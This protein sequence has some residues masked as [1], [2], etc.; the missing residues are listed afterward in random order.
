[1]RSV[2][3]F[4][5]IA[6]ATVGT[7]LGLAALPGNAQVLDQSQE[8]IAGSIP[9]HGG[10]AAWQVFMAERIGP[11]TSVDL[12]L[13]IACNVPP[14]AG[15]P[16]DLKVDIVLTDAG[17]IPAATVVSSFSLP[18]TEAGSTLQWVEIPLSPAVPVTQGTVL[19]I[20]LTGGGANGASS[21]TWMWGF[22]ESLLDPYLLGDYF[23]DADPSNGLDDP[24]TPA[25]PPGDAAFRTYVVTHT[26][27]DG[28]E[29]TPEECD[30][31][32]TVG[33]D[34]C[35]AS[36]EDEFCGDGLVTS[37]EEC[38]DGGTIAGDGCDAACALE[39]AAVACRSAIAKGGSKY[40]TARMKALL[41]CRNLLAAGK[42]LSVDDPAQCASE[43]AAAKG[44]AKAAASARK[45]I[46]SGKKPKCT[47]AWVGVLGACA[48]TVD[49]VID[50][51]ATSGCLLATHGDAV[52]ELLEHYGY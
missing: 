44:I 24:M 14:C 37:V 48:E 32:N 35:S 40:A 20:R 38:D 50:A 4:A 45:G 12:P 15:D 49:G 17:D 8:L 46:A 11:L 23:I 10:I 13:A 41:R 2:R 31:G 36:C 3:R 25:F 47:D 52:D 18:S 27:G 5:P 16:G 19:A 22:A 42:S 43:T 6:A 26:C 39:P 28:A 51:A 34:G 33:G 1:M 30:D 9:I 21:N 7:A 29:E